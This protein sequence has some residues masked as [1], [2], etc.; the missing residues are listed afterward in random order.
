MEHSCSQTTKKHCPFCQKQFV[1]LGNHLSRCKERQ[2]RDYS[3]YLS[4]KTLAKRAGRVTSN[5]ICPHCHKQFRRL[6]THLQ[7]NATCKIIA[8]SS[9]STMESSVSSATSTRLATPEQ[10]SN[11]EQSVGQLGT[12][13]HMHTKQALSL[14][15]TET[16]WQEADMYFK[17]FLV[18]CVQQTIG[19]SEKNELLTSGVYDY[20]ART[21]GTKSLKTSKRRVKSQSVAAKN[22]ADITQRKNEARSKLRKAKREGSTSTTGI[23]ELATSFFHRV[24]AHS[25]AK[26]QVRTCEKRCSERKLWKMCHHNFW[27]FSKQL[28]DDNCGSNT[29]PQFSKNDAESYFCEIY[30]SGPRNFA[31]PEWLPSPSLPKHEFNCDD[32]SLD[33]VRRVI[34]HSKSSSTPSPHDQIGYNIFKKCPSLRLALLDIYTACW[35]ENTVPNAWKVAVI[36]LLP[37]PAADQEPTSPANFRPIA[38]TSCVGKIFTKILQHRWQGFMLRNRIATSRKH[39]YHQLAAQISMPC[40]ST[41]TLPLQ[42]G[43]YQGD[44]L[45]VSIFNTV[46][47][48]LV[49]TLQTR[50][51]LGYIF[52]I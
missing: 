31:H 32:I 40:W 29:D 22:L 3:I 4:A 17:D 12:D 41:T 50:R 2:G 37:K 6:D 39:F 20:F 9:R 5:T 11:Q 16:E 42:I 46:I 38:L 48:T 47:N 25:I 18:P 14:P 36:K 35:E 27:K 44:P 33:E 7:R 45:S 51:D 1:G 43:V 19:V 28:L 52:T 23:K 13:P 8:V 15:R 26:R 21:F 30:S 49:D 24:R 10:E 34:K